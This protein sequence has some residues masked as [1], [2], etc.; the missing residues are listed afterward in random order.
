M[1]LTQEDLAERANLHRTF[2]SDVERGVKNPSL[3]IVERLAG[4]LEISIAD[5]L[6]AYK[7]ETPLKD[8]A[9]DKP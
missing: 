9:R 4:A 5:L 6:T 1:D 8:S 3:E 7:V 2:I